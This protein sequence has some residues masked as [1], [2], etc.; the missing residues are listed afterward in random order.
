MASQPYI[1]EIR[2]FGGNFAPMGWA[3]CQGQLMPIDQNPALYQLIGTTYGGDGQTT[4][5]LPDLRSRVPVH[6]GQSAG[7]S[8]YVLGQQTGV[9]TVTLAAN[10]IPQHSHNPPAC[11]SANGTSDNPAG[12][13]WAGS[14]TMLYLS[15]AGDSTM[16]AGAI[17]S[18]GGSQPHDNMLPFL[19][20]NFI[21]S[22]FGIFPSQN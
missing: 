21:I 5:A 20:V 16:N 19:V 17:G 8:N 2:M 13:R 10:Q 7:T 11:N 15:G 1:G 4:F 22:L 18:T 6:M 3:L 12:N 14:P 9:E